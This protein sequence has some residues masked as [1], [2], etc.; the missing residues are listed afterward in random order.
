MPAPPCKPSHTQAEADALRRSQSASL[1]SIAK[2]FSRFLTRVSLTY[3]CAVVSQAAP[4][5]AGFAASSA[6][7]VVT[8]LYKVLKYLSTIVSFFVLLF[9]SVFQAV[10]GS[11]GSASTA[12]TRQATMSVAM[13]PSPLENC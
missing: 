4:G 6:A 9:S 12:P 7:G 5:C 8:D 1:R 3:I 13:S 2:W 10:G 11:V